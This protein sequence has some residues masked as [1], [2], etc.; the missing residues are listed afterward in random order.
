LVHVQEDC[1]ADFT[2]ACSLLPIMIFVNSNNVT[3]L[4][5]NCLGGALNV[6]IKNLRNT[7]S[8]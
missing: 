4:Q 2:L 7:E 6:V 8:D 1:D 5:S 3:E